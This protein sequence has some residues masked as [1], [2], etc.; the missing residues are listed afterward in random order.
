MEGEGMSKML[1]K[2]SSWL[3]IW[4]KYFNNLILTFIPSDLLSKTYLLINRV[5]PYDPMVCEAHHPPVCLQ[6]GT[7]YPLIIYCESDPVN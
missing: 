3:G 4:K 5:S 7:P 6:V 2:H 1:S